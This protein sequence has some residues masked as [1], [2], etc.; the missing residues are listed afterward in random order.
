MNSIILPPGLSAEAVALMGQHP[1][2]QQNKLRP[3][4]DYTAR[5]RSPVPNQSESIAIQ[6]YYQK[7]GVHEIL[8][9]DSSRY[10]HAIKDVEFAATVKDKICKYK[11]LTL[12]IRQ[13]EAE[14]Q[15][16]EG[17][18][19]EIKE[20]TANHQKAVI[21]TL[22][23]CDKTVS[24]PASAQGGKRKGKKVRRQHERKGRA[25]GTTVPNETANRVPDKAGGATVSYGSHSTGYKAKPHAPVPWREAF[26]EPTVRRRGNCHNCK[27]PGHHATDHW[28]YRCQGCQKDAPGH[29]SE[30]CPANRLTWNDLLNPG[31]NEFDNVA[32]GNM[33]D[34]PCG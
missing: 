11:E 12:K 5:T 23:H 15:E 3:D 17:K 1:S 24:A 27:K 26:R 18:R 21:S 22:R 14:V 7:M 10:D 29:S 25:A 33:F 28:S 6:A 31:V 30:E 34:E 16:I 32:C 4:F 20:W 8:H 13:L 19:T 9:T 2:F